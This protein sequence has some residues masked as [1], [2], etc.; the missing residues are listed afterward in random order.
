MKLTRYLYLLFIVAMYVINYFYLK[1][2]WFPFTGIVLA[3]LIVIIIGVNIYVKLK[4]KSKGLHSDDFIFSS[5]VAQTIK[6]VDMGIQYESSIIALFFLMV[7]L[8]LMIIY[9][10]FFTQYNTIMKVFIAFNS[11][12]ALIL[13]SS[14]LITNYQ[15]FISYKESTRMFAEFTNKVGTEVVSQ[16][17][18][19]ESKPMT[20]LEAY[21]FPPRGVSD[22]ER[23]I[24]PKPIEGMDEDS[25]EVLLNRLFENKNE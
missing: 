6:K 1:I 2:N 5:E 12:F 4:N 16:D 7:G 19:V 10:V 24:L 9:T 13:M 23:P 3:S 17:K 15:Q 11:F 22:N 20:P 14:M 8:I 21:G 25:D 18:L